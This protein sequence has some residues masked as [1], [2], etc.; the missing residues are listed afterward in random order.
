MGCA[1]L[2]GAIINPITDIDINGL[3]YILG[4]LIYLII[5]MEALFKVIFSD[6][7][8]FGF[9]IR[10]FVKATILSLAHLSPIYLL[11]ATV[12]VDIIIATL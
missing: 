12:I 3:F 11:A 8:R 1:C 7:K 2:Q 5:F 9:R 6:L 10:I 4:I